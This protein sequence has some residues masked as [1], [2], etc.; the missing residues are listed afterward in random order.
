[1]AAFETGVEARHRAWRARASC[2]LQAQSGGPASIRIAECFATRA[3]SRHAV[4]LGR[5]PI[6]WGRGIQGGMLLGRS[7]RPFWQGRWRTVRPLRLPVLA[8]LGRWQGDAFLGYLDD[9]RRAVA[10]PLL[11]GH[12]FAWQPVEWLEVA[13]TRTMLFG[14]RGRTRRLNAGDLGNILLGRGENRVGPR[15]P[16]D[17]DQRASF[18]AWGGLPAR[19][20]RRLGLDGGEIY[21]EYAGEDAIHPPLPAAVGHLL[22]GA[23]QRRGWQAR[24]E[25]AETVSRNRWY[26]AHSVYR[27]SHFFRGDPLGVSF[28]PDVESNALSLATPPGALRVRL[29]RTEQLLGKISGNRERRR[30]WNALVR[31][32]LG[33]RWTAEC[34]IHRGRR[35]GSGYEPRAPALVRHA[36][37]LRCTVR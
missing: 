33:E 2:L 34:E 8:R 18:E 10:D 11:L 14:G 26:D 27:D 9:E 21:F 35:L 13:G 37:I 22:G 7:A 1:M 28:G 12:R 4:L 6:R 15:G 31:V 19:A 5:A 3:G 30:L 32:D 23:L 16:G 20:A 36:A 29:A 25:F 17:S 24:I